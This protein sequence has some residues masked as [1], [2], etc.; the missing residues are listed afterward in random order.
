MYFHK[1]VEG[2]VG[3]EHIQNVGEYTPE[4]CVESVVTVPVESSIGRMLYPRN[5]PE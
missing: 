3:R 1:E 2:R 5:V 4:K